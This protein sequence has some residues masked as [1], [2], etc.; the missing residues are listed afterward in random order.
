MPNKHV[1]SY[2]LIK[3]IHEQTMHAGKLNI[4]GELKRKYWMPNAKRAIQHAINTEY[5][6]KCGLCMKLKVEAFKSPIEPPLPE[7][8]L[9]TG[10]AFEH[11]GVDYFGPYEL[12]DGSK[13]YVAL[14]TC[15]VYRCL[16]FEVA[17]NRKANTFMHVFRRFCARRGRPKVILSDNDKTFVSTAETL[18][19]LWPT[20]PIQWHFITPNASARGGVYER[21]VKIA[22]E[23]L[24]GIAGRRTVNKESFETIVL[25]AE[26]IANNRPISYIADDDLKKPLRPIHFLEPAPS[27]LKEISLNEELFDDA[28]YQKAWPKRHI[29]IKRH[30]EIAK[31]LEF[32]KQEWIKHYLFMLRDRHNAN[33][34]NNRIPQVGEIVLI[35]SEE[36]KKLRW[37]L[38]RIV[39]LINDDKGYARTAKVQVGSIALGKPRYMLRAIYQLYPLECGTTSPNSF[40]VVAK[41]PF[42]SFSHDQASLSI[43]KFHLY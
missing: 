1:I 33:I 43:N 5:H 12:T 39:K 26:R 19:V 4:L 22:K 30:Q 13:N 25:E 29:L 41:P 7:F 24:K 8:R 11:V 32:F 42:T 6:T 31:D 15:L 36:K 35:E 9:N 16:H 40:Q 14:F 17:W 18:K 34:K 10:S 20:A 38:G 3:H 28:S 37:K 2:M 27:K 23:C 21:M